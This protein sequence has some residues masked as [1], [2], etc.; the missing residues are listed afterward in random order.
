MDYIEFFKNLF[1]I[2]FGVCAGLILAFR[3]VWPKIEALI[4]KTKMLNKKMSDQ[5]GSAIG[6]R[7]HLKA[8]AYE[9]LLL[10][11]G[12]IEPRNLIARH[13]EENQNVRT[14]HL[15]LIQEVENEFQYNF[16]QQ[17]YVS[18]DAWEAVRLLK[19]NTV[20]LLNKALN[21]ATDTQEAYAEEV[22]K[23]LSTLRPDPYQT[24]QLI[25]K[26]EANR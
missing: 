15:R 8:G 11:T 19:E 7:E 21:D 20:I 10:F 2:A 17:L 5:K 1:L 23:F 4:I 24:A 6:E 16:T 13:L 18:A 26:Q 22:L 12:R 25:L 9:R 14:L 3:L